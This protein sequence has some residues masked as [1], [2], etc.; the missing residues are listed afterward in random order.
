[1]FLFSILVFIFGSFE[2]SVAFYSFTGSSD[3][4]PV[5]N[6][7]LLNRVKLFPLS[8]Q[9]CKNNGFDAASTPNKSGS[10]LAYPN[11]YDCLETYQKVTRQGK[12]W[13]ISDF[14][15]GISHTLSSPAILIYLFICVREHSVCH[16]V[17]TWRVDWVPLATERMFLCYG[18]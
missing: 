5:S 17:S 10:G 16:V 12:P 1:M 11:V 7:T 15:C 6:S 4:F 14:L 13:Y 2:T 8:R 18:R 3:V 9:L